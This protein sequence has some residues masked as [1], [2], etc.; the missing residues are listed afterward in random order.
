MFPFESGMALSRTV[1]GTTLIQPSQTP[2]LHDTNTRLKWSI[3][4]I[5]SFSERLAIAIANRSFYRVPPYSFTSFAKLV[6]VLVHVTQH[7]S[8]GLSNEGRYVE[9]YPGKASGSPKLLSLLLP[10]EAW[11][12][13]TASSMLASATAGN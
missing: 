3:V 5:L 2:T 7:T 9:L 13:G 1:V 4:T 11:F 6:V 8:W 10:G 12:N